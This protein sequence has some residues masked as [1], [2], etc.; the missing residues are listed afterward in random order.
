MTNGISHPYHLDESIFIFRG[1]RGIVSFL[2]H[3]SM[4]FMK[5]NRIAS[6]ETPRSAAFYLGLFCL[7]MSH[8][9]DARLKWAKICNLRQIK[10]IVGK[11][12]ISTLTEQK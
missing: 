11:I 2:S 12:N 10:T 7:H 5:V 8:K 9:N 3:F 6:D 4:K 1:I